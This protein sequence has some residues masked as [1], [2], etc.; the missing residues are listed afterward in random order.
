ME[1]HRRTAIHIF[2]AGVLSQGCSIGTSGSEVKRMPERPIEA[3]LKDH[4]SHLM[5][6]PGVV[7][8]AQTECS[9]APCIK[10]YVKNK[11]PEIVD[12]IPSKIEEYPVL[13]EESGEIRPLNTR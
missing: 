11:T 9:G 5:A 13:I 3:V 6:L 12:L 7:G 8:T 4:T 2:L 10:V 1:S